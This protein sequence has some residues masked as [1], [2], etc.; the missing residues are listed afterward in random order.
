MKNLKGES[1]QVLPMAALCIGLL[2]GF[3]ALAIDVGLLYRAK[4][5]MQIAADAG[6]V[7]GAAELAVGDISAAG[8]AGAA[9]NGF[10]NG[11]NGATVT[12][13]NPPLSGAYAGTKNYVEVIVSQSEPV[14]FMKVF[15]FGAVNVSARAVATDVPS[16]TCIYTLSSASAGSSDSPVG[17]VYVTG[18]ADLNLPSCGII[19]DGTGSYAVHVT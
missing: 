15:G 6:A 1:G 5:N 11:V 7:D 13:N 18:S 19:D 4:R 10:A 3:M 2:M 14:F 16:P 9:L 17:G 8:N 12:V